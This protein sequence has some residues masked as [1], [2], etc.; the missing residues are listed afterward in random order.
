MPL[1]ISE[2]KSNI[3]HV[4]HAQQYIA[5]MD[6]K[7]ETFNKTWTILR[8]IFHLTI[9]SLHCHNRPLYSHSTSLSCYSSDSNE[10]Q[11]SHRHNPS[12][13]VLEISWVLFACYDILPSISNP[14]GSTYSSSLRI[15][16]GATQSRFL[17]MTEHERY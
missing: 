2:L 4:F 5:L 7:Q 6:M 13:S 16:K 17:S 3:R 8:N 11:L 10:E 1:D 15:S 12:N 14:R 9:S